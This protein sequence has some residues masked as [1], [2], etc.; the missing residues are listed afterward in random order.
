MITW[1]IASKTSANYEGAVGE[2]ALKRQ[3][4]SKPRILIGKILAVM[5]K[6]LFFGTEDSH[7]T[8]CRRVSGTSGVHLQ[9]PVRS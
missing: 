6:L 4:Q 9:Q 2:N 5:I 3:K 1:L 8:R 7:Q